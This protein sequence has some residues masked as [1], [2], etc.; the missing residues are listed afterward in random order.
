MSANKLVVE[1]S[2]EMRK[3]AEHSDVQHRKLAM[4][5]FI[6]ASIAAC[7][8]VTITHPFDVLKTRR[9]LQNELVRT[10]QLDLSRV[11]KISIRSVWRWEGASGVYRGLMPAYIYQILMNGFR[12]AIY[13]PC[14]LTLGREAKRISGVDWLQLPC[15]V[16]SGA[17]AG[18][19]AAAVGSPFNLVKTRLQS[20]SQHFAT[21][22]QHHYRGMLDAFLRIGRSGEGIRGFYHGAPAAMVR[23]SVGSAVQLSSYDLFKGM[24]V[25]AGLSETNIGVHFV[26]ALTSGFLVC[27]AMNPFDVIMTRLYNQSVTQGQALYTGLVDCGMKTVKIEGWRAL[28]KGFAPHYIRIGPHTLLTLMFLEQVR[29]VVKPMIM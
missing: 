16:V 12:F 5:Q 14:R 17:T 7:G 10:S 3:V 26:A 21:G 13:E 28:F 4:V 11:E 22:H 25:S 6:S 2:I 29:A 27:V 8:A 23:T 15:N 20:N 24:A 9:Q 1:Q 19:I 18:A